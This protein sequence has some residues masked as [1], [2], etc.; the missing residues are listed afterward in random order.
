MDIFE[1]QKRKMIQDLEIGDKVDSFFK[2]L[3]VSKRKKRDGESYLALVLMDK[4]GKIPAKVWDNAES[5]FKMLVEGEIYRIRGYVNEYQNKKEIKIDS[6]RSVSPNDTDY[7]KNDFIESAP[8]DT[9][10]LFKEMIETIRSNIQNK[11][12]L[13]LV[14]L[15]SEKYKE[16]FKVHYGAQKIHHAYTGG[17][18]KHTF[19]IIQL[20]IFAADHYAIDKELL[21]IGALFHDVGKLFEYNIEPSIN[22]TREGGL[23]GHIV[24]GN[25]IFLELKDR[26]ENFPEDLSTKIQHMILSHHGEKEFG[27]P[28]VPK[29]PEAFVLYILDLLDSKVDFIKNVINSSDTKGLFS[30]YLNILGRRLYVPPE[31]N[32]S[33]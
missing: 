2:M 28:E 14:G 21:L 8:F 10:A 15:F 26:I 29:I 6:I 1:N 13:E 25:N 3:N 18:L 17:L 27:S 19:S 12:L 11:Y 5:S 16:S 24:I 7:D 22:T 33:D 32:S 9:E 20:S 30:D 31:D 4:T 23:V